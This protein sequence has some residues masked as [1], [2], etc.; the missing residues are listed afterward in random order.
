[1]DAADLSPADW[2][3]S[4]AHEW[5]PPG[6]GDLYPAMLGSGTLDKLLAKGFK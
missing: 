5:C 6:H 1:V 4:R 2:P 3:A